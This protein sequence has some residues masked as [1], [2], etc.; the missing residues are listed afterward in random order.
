ML[1]TM[2]LQSD[3]TYIGCKKIFS[4]KENADY[5]STQGSKW[6]KL[7][8]EAGTESQ[9]RARERKLERAEVLPEKTGGSGKAK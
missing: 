4:A 9:I 7:V 1:L 2:T 3:I 8:Q 6:K 5:Q